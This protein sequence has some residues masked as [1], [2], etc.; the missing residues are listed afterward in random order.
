MNPNQSEAF[1]AQPECVTCSLQFAPPGDDRKTA[2]LFGELE[3]ELVAA[4]PDREPMPEY[5]Q[6]MFEVAGVPR[7]IAA[8][9][10]LIWV[11]AC[12]MSAKYETA[13][14]RVNDDA[15]WFELRVTG[16]TGRTQRLRCNRYGDLLEF[17]DSAGTDASTQLQN[18]IANV[19]L[20]FKEATHQLLI[21]H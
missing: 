10:C 9:E 16:Q 2:G 19:L 5:I 7:N 8:G 13:S 20:D 17:E 18:V 4:L 15:S 11:N 3:D 21:M 1:F 6:R 14:A 12:K